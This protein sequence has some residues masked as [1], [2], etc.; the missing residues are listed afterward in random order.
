MKTVIKLLSLVLVALCFS[1]LL[2]ADDE[3]ESMPKF[4]PSMMAAMMQ[5]SH[6]VEAINWNTLSKCLPDELEGYKTGKL[7][8]GTYNMD[9]PASP[10]QKFSY[11]NVE[12]PFT[13]GT[14]DG[15]DKEIKISFMDSGLNQMLIAPFMMHMEFDSPDGSMKWTKIN[16]RKS[17][18]MIDKDEG[19]IENIHILTILADRLIVMVEGNELTS[20]DEVTNIAKKI[21]YACLDKLLKNMS[22]EDMDKDKDKDNEKEE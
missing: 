5:K 12:R 17:A 4:D 19:K 20:V 9:N 7:D 22:K 14:K 13:V 2:W 18:L 8:G 10:G 21:D 11:S 3:S 15:D 16:D 1:G 6:S